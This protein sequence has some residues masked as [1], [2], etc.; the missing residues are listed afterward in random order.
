[1]HGNGMWKF[2]SAAALFSFALGLVLIPL[3]AASKSTQ[4]A[5]SPQSAAAEPV[6]AYHAQPPQG[7]LPATLHPELFPGP[8]VQNAYAVAAIIKKTLY[9]P[10]CYCHYPPN[11]D[12]ATLLQPSAT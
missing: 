10:P 3:R 12:H 8:V 7:G 1:M 11:H 5:I 2:L 4:G 9:Q 6:P